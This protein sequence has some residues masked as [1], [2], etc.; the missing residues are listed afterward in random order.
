MKKSLVIIYVNLVDFF[1]RLS[2]F[3]D[4]ALKLRY[5]PG[6]NKLRQFN[7]KARAGAQFF[8]AYKNVPAYRQFLLRENFKRIPFIGILPDMSSVP[9]T[10]KV[11]YVNAFEINQRCIN[12]KIP[13]EGVI[14]DESSGSSGMPTNWVRGK[15]ETKVNHRLIK[16]GLKSVI[17]PAP[18]F[19]INAFA[20]GAWATGMNITMSCVK[21][22]KIKSTGPDPA[23]IINTIKQFGAGHN[24][25]IMGYPPFLKRLIDCADLEW[26]KYNI[27]LIFGGE[28]MTEG[29]RDYLLNKG[30]KKI[31]SSFGASDLELNIAH[32]NDFTVSLRRLIRENASLKN[33]IIK[34]PGALP[35]VF[36]F[37][38]SDFWIDCNDLG[39][40]IFTICR[41]GYIAPKIRYNIYDK[42]HVM[43]IDVLIDLLKQ[44]GLAE[45]I[46]RP[47][48]DLPLLFHYGRADMT[49]SFFGS[50]ISPNDI[51]EVIFMMPELAGYINSF[52]L[53]TTEDSSSDKQLVVSV[54][55]LENS[56]PDT[57]GEIPYLTNEFF[58]NLAKINQDFNAACAMA[59]YNKPVLRLYKYGAG[60][61]ENEDV[62]IKAK[63][64]RTP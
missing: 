41:P 63:Y 42:G 38:P 37:N 64:I 55:L 5:M 39:E 19:A 61:F 32:E 50:N 12:G 18:V 36:Q 15:K 49:V 10:T 35:M 60:P 46:V 30:I 44:Q 22:S 3:S 17:G 62:R 21:F 48:T 14:I 6:F 13:D 2:M 7:A 9:V 53:E 4:T 59:P 27:T 47:Q 33:E 40:L 29:M 11:N 28:S 16:F 45:K 1:I 57:F 31:Y 54:E 43:Q 58:M 23:K 8:R 52:C 20:L 26:D 56:M 34:Y 24:Y 25:V 51:Q